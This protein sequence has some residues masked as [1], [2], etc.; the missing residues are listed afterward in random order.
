MADAHGQD[1][2]LRPELAPAWLRPLVAELGNETHAGRARE[3]L[4]TRVPQRGGKDQSAVLILFTGNPDAETLPA[5]AGLLITHRHPNL[6][7]HSG[8]MAFP[9]GHIEDADGGPVDAALREAWEETG[10]DRGRVTP[11]AVLA[12]VTTGGSRRRVRPV[13]GYAADPG[14]V[15]PASEEETDDVF[16]VPVSELIDPANRLT[17]GWRGWSGPAFWA[18]C[19][20]V[21]GFTG[22]LVSVLLD[23]AGWAVPW[24]ET[25]R[26]LAEVLEGSCNDEKSH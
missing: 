26:G 12:P 3:L 20:V 8:Q 19:Y 25:P 11:L 15:H 14:E 16:F 1:T 13:L 17:V 10:L 24:D 21:W 18:G 4:A 2:A 9:G 23:L 6:R 5:D 7:S 22:V